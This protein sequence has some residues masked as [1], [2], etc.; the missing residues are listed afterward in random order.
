MELRLGVFLQEL[1]GQPVP[2]REQPL[3]GFHSRLHNGLD[4]L[5]HTLI[6]FVGGGGVD[7][8]LA[9]GGVGNH[10]DGIVVGALFV[11]KFQGEG[12]GGLVVGGHERGD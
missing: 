7:N 10:G 4:N 1:L 8:G 3:A 12:L 6:G 11:M 9:I 5:L 2:H